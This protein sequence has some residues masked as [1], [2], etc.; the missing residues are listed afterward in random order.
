MLIYSLLSARDGGFKI[1][2]AFSPIVFGKESIDEIKKVTWP[3]RDEV[4]RLTIAVLA[5]SIIVGIYLGVLDALINIIFELV[6]T[7]QI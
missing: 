1:V 5:I 6:I 3:T 7:R 4:I 2:M